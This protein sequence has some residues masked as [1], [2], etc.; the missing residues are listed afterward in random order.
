MDGKVKVAIVGCGDIA[1]RHIVGL[2][3]FEDIE[4]VGFYDLVK[5][6][7]EK[8]AQ[9]SGSGKGF[10]CYVTMLDESKPDAL[11]VCVPPNQ[12]GMIEFE[13]IKR[14]IHMLIQK[15]ITTDID[16]AVKICDLANQHNIIISVGF[17]DRYMDI[18]EPMKELLNSRKIGLIN[19]AW[20]GGIPESPWWRKRSSSGGQII[21]QTI[22]H[23]DM[24]RYL[25]GEPISIYTASGKGIINLLT[26]N[27]IGYDVE[28]YSTTTITFKNGSIA[29]IFSG[30]YFEKGGGMKNC[31]VFYAAN[32]TIEYSL[33]NKVALIIGNEIEKEFIKKEDQMVMLDRTF[34]N[35]IKSGSVS[36]IS[37]IRSS[38]ADAIKT[39]R[40]VLAANMSIDTGK[41]IDLDL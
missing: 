24:L 41:V 8:T 31:L 11:Y 1:N 20:A 7:S 29:N 14:G 26:Q 10:D 35:A 3:K 28:E 40:F 6:N 18:I 30:N 38:Y 19:G 34:I 23:F 16:L 5:S 15:P 27:L 33:R 4:F 36:D 32:S 9:M 22:H 17:Q 37:K 39:L 21:E 25:I 12:H 2:K 13:A